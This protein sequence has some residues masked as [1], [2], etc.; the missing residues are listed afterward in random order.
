LSISSATNSAFAYHASN[1]SDIAGTLKLL[2]TPLRGVGPAT[3]SLLL[4]IYDPANVIFFSDEVYYW[5]VAGGQKVSLKY[6]SSEF[7][8]AHAQCQLLQARLNVTPTEIEKVAFVIMKEKEPVKAPKEKPAPTG[9]KAGRP[10]LEAS[11]RKVASKTSVPGR[12]RGRPPGSGN[13]VPTFDYGSGRRGRNHETRSGDGEDETEEDAE[14]PLENGKR[15]A[16]D[17]AVGS[18]KKAKH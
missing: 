13:L 10:K 1:P 12:K 6:T 11:E 5:L 7:V 4:A 17:D 16:K 18:T 14:T 2:S 9:K 3:A 8:A 15:K